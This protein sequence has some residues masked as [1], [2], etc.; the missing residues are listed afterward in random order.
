MVVGRQ[1]KGMLCMQEKGK[2][3]IEMGGLHETV[4]V[5]GRWREVT[6]AANRGQ[7]EGNQEKGQYILQELDLTPVQGNKEEEQY[8]S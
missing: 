6:G 8:K 7:C 1:L 5:G 2:M 4:K 3:T